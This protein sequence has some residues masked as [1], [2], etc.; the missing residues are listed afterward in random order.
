[1]AD[2]GVFIGFG[3]P[4]RGRENDA[5]GVFNELIAYLGG[6]AQQGNVESFEPGFMQPHGGELGGFMLVRGG[7]SKLDAMVASDEFVRITMKA[8]MVVDHMGV[9]NVSLGQEIEKQ[10]GIFLESAAELGK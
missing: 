5:A 1:V 3:F 4:A 7:R 10:M 6:Q 8:Q 9:V 2:F